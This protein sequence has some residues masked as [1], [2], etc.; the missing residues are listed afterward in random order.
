MMEYYSVLKTKEILSLTTTQMK[1]EESKLSEINQSQK[2]F[3]YMTP[4]RRT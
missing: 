2:D 4:L 1:L 3:Y